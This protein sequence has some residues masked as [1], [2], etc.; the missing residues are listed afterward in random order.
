MGVRVVVGWLCELAH[1]SA[2]H[3]VWRA[4]GLRPR[5]LPRPPLGLGR[6]RGSRIV[7]ALHLSEEGVK[8]ALDVLVV[9]GG[10][11]DERSAELLRKRLA[12]GRGDPSLVLQVTLLSN[13][14]TRD[15]LEASLV[16]DLLVQRRDHIERL[17][18]RNAVHEHVAVNAGRVLGREKRELVLSGSVDNLAVVLDAL[19]LDRLLIC[20]LNRRVVLLVVR[21]GRDVLLGDRRLTWRGLSTQVTLAGVSSGLVVR[22]TATH[23]HWEIQGSPPCASFHLRTTLGR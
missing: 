17:S 4:L 11:L 1:R 18:G 6:R 2:W 13:N 12:L 9:L 7:L 22:S 3:C 5:T 8:G 16:E 20:G 23:Q 15:L 10:G 21:R 14:D 19:V